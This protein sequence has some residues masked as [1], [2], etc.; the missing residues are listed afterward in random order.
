MKNVSIK[1]KITLWYLI[2][3]T[4]MVIMIIIFILA[5]SNTVFNQTAM[6]RIS[7]AVRDNLRQINVSQDGKLQ[8]GENFYFYNNGVYTLIY[9]KEEALLAGQIPVSFTEKE[10]FEN[11]LTRI[12]SSGDTNYY[13]FD[14]WD[15]FDW[16]TG[17]WVRGLM[18]VP[19]EET[20]INNLIKVVIIAMPVF[21]LLSTIGGYIIVKRA[22]KPLENIISTANDINEGSDLSARIEI[23]CGNNEL[24]RLACTFDEMFSRLEA[25]F[26]AEK[27]FTSDASHE[28]RTPIS[29][30]KSAC[31]YAQKYDETPE[32]REE[33]ISM[34]YRQITRM[35]DLVSQLL[36][37]TRLEQGTEIAKLESVNFTNFIKLIYDEQIYKKEYILLDLEKNIEAEIDPSLMSRLIQ[38][39][40]DNAFKYGKENGHV[41]LILKKADKEIIF[42]VKDDGIGISKENQKKI[43]QRFFQVDSSR[44]GGNGVGLGLSMVKKIAELH[45]GFMTLESEIDKGSTFT[46]HMPYIEMKP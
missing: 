28:L 45:G 41:W 16:E 11:G 43:W 8:L 19:E 39:L 30:I 37:I 7:Q 13:V 9:S 35:S 26:E 12:V 31:E 44:T 32:E 22:F 2:L 27:Q 18:E 29:V 1:A 6:S 17:V 38:N 25:S 4:I 14:L 36:N 46:L 34:I 20:M 40:I 23:P 3:M 24:T 42:S 33:T 21:I 10:N 15:P 5:V